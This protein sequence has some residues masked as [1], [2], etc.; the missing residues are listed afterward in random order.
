M[1][2]APAH[3]ADPRSSVPLNPEAPGDLNRAAATGPGRVALR[4]PAWHSRLG[5]FVLGAVLLW[6]LAVASEF[7]PWILLS[8][9]SL[10]AA[11][12]FLS[13]FYP[14][15]SSR[16]FLDLVLEATWQTIAIATAG[17]TLGWLAAVPLTIVSTARLSQS[18]IGRPMGRLPLLLRQS[19]RWLLVFLRSVPELVWALLFVRIVGLGPTAGVLA[20]AL[21][22]AGM[23]GKVYGEILE[24]TDPAPTDALL[25]NGASRVKALAWGALPQAAPELASYTVFRWECAI[26]SSVIMGFVGGGG[27]GQQMDLSMK[28]LAGGEV[29]TM[30]I[31][32]MLLVALAD[33]VSRMLR[34]AM[35]GEHASGA[36]GTTGAIGETRPIN[37]PALLLGFVALAVASFVTLD[38][39]L[40]AFLE[41]GA[42]ARM[43]EFIGGFFPPNGSPG[44]LL[45]V[46]EATLETIAMS[47]LGTLIAVVFGLLLAIPAAHRADARTGLASAA[48][49]GLAAKAMRALA[50]LLLNI[51]R[52]IPELVWA[53]LWLI[54]A[55]LG[56]LAGTLALAAHTTGV[57]GRLF[58]ETLENLPPAPARALA[59]HGAS[60]AS[61]LFYATLPQALPQLLSY[62]LYRWENNIRAA[63]VLGVVGA[64]GLGQMLYFH[65]SLFQ[66]GETAAIVIAMFAIVLLVDALSYF[67]RR[68]L[69]T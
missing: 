52:S 38:L 8:D 32:F 61:I 3:A 68:R 36:I 63:A 30:L 60:R 65:L 31:V 6:P 16:E 35:D 9:S 39:A 18:A 1:R 46:A 67:A 25:R 24:S 41:P 19:V 40:A 47:L 49:A 48:G 13:T 5:W 33:W 57:L 42:L 22:Y 28:M 55:G 34:D 66:M 10:D 37:G 51:C 4:D 23:L 21:T 12:A 15:E 11:G 17:L 7:K 64:G 56:P 69:T 54:A 59:D 26:R 29:A 45:R 2:C 58:A 44:F 20:I 27:L 14:P 50:R 53:A 62:T 43:A